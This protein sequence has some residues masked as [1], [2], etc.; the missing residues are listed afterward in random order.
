VRRD[1]VS[2][3]A[4]LKSCISRCAA[5]AE[6]VVA[7]P[8]ARTA[9]LRLHLVGSR[10]SGRSPLRCGHRPANR[11]DI[12]LNA[13]RSQHVLRGD[14]LGRSASPRMATSSGTSATGDGRPSACRDARPACSRKRLVGLVDEGSTFRSAAEAMMSAR[15]PPR[16][17]GVITCEWAPSLAAIVSRESVSFTFRC[18]SRPARRA[19]RSKRQEL[20]DRRRR[21]PQSSWSVSRAAAASHRSRSASGPEPLPFPEKS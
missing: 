15:G 9:A 14:G 19:R 10:R 4:R 18:G 2:R 3:I 7:G 11:T 6:V 16:A 5:D 12:M 21:R 8:L 17:F 1:P 20:M 13:P